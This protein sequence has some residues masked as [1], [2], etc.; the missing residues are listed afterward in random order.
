MGCE[1]DRIWMG[2]DRVCRKEGWE[3]E[4]G[5]S[6]QVCPFLFWH[7][8]PRAHH[9]WKWKKCNRASV[10]LRPK[11]VWVLPCT[12]P[13]PVHPTCPIPLCN[14]PGG[15]VISCHLT[16]KGASYTPQ[17]LASLE[18]L[19]WEVGKSRM[20]SKGWGGGEHLKQTWKINPKQSWL[21]LTARLA[22]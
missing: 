16:V 8:K 12:H 20:K 13:V 10:L 17:D 3:G 14:L 22:G 7:P 19:C 2:W 5:M 1:P 21:V 4:R 18:V 11:D 6:F 15:T 9:W